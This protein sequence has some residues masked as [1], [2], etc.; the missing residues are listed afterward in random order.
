MNPERRM[1]AFLPRS[2]CYLA[3]LVTVLLAVVGLNPR[4]LGQ[5]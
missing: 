2:P 4:A 1:I 5:G 3:N